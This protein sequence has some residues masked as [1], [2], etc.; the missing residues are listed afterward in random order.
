MSSSNGVFSSKED[1]WFRWYERARNKETALLFW[2][3][4]ANA[5][6]RIS[7]ALKLSANS[8]AWNAQDTVQHWLHKPNT[9]C[10]NMFGWLGGYRCFKVCALT[11]SSSLS[12]RVGE[13]SKARPMR[14]VM[15]RLSPSS[16]QRSSSCFSRIVVSASF[17]YLSQHKQQHYKNKSATNYSIK[18]LRN[19]FVSFGCRIIDVYKSVHSMQAHTNSL[20]IYNTVQKIWGRLD[21]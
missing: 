7:S 14:M 9:M 17:S 13:K 12:I 10:S 18:N 2:E 20:L 8:R 4:S 11:L 15:V 5:T 16:V 6:F 21:F 3:A 19:L 1:F